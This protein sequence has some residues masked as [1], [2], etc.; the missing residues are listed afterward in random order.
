MAMKGHCGADYPRLMDFSDEKGTS[1][2]VG[3]IQSNG[4][5]VT[6]N[7]TNPSNN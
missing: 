1:R 3:E 4:T 2:D 5:V 6:A 7:E